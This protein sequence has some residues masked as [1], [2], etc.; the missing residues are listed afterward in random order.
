MTESQHPNPKPENESLRETTEP[1]SHSRRWLIGLLVVIVLLG[2]FALRQRRKKSEPH[3]EA[4]AIAT[5]HIKAATTGQGDMG[6]YIQALGNVTPLATVNLYSQ[7]TG[8]VVSVHYTE[9][10][11]V[12]RGDPLIDIDP[13]PYQAQ[14]QQAQGTLERDRAVLQQAEIDL[15]R[16]QEASAVD[17]I[18]RQTFEDQKLVVDQY[19]GTVKNDEGQVQYAQAELGYCHLVSP[20]NGRV[21]LRLV[22]P[23]NTI[24]S[25]GNNPIVVV[26]QLQPITVIFNVAEDYLDQVRGEITRRHGLQVDAFDR[27]KE[28]KIAS[29]AMLTLDNQ[30]DTSTGTI[31]FRGQF[32]NSDLALFPNQF[33]NARLLVKTLHDVVLAPKAA[34]QHNGTQAFVYVV[35]D[36]KVKLQ[37]ITVLAEDGDHAAVNGIQR[38]QMVAVTGFDKVQ[39]G[40]NVILQGNPAAEIASKTGPEKAGL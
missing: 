36:N 9:G 19:H 40:M 1:R 3:E 28:T 11:I 18:A 23:G 5:P 22:D 37:P 26:T 13:V 4:A 15:K 39:D 30:V 10:Q 21:G 6:V 2:L 20:I 7:I 8:R 27:S 33:V 16:Y 12:H 24:F 32:N 29:G 25:G 35:I 31:R 38:G 34:I 14:L 17:A